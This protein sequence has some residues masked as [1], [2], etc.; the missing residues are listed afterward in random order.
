MTTSAGI[1]VTFSQQGNWK[2][3]TVDGVKQKG[4]RETRSQT[5]LSKDTIIALN[6]KLK[7][8]KEDTLHKFL[9]GQM[10]LLETLLN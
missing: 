5:K 9:Q 2:T 6:R 4:D 8:T 10:Q 3:K 1:S 7:L